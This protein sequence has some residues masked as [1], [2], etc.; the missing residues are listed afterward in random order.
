MKKAN[1]QKK[2]KFHS[3]F[4]INCPVCGKHKFQI[5]QRI[6]KI[7]YFGE[8]LETFATCD[9]CKYKTNDILPL[10]Q[11][12]AQSKQEL[13]VKT[14]KDLN[15]RL[16]KSKFCTIEIPEI[17]L[18]IEPGPGSEAFITNIEGLLHRI[19]KKI[20]TMK[21]LNPSKSSELDKILEKVKK[22]HKGKEKFTLIFRDKTGQSMIF[23]KT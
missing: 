22:M 10:E 6:D 16:V 20:G 5:V 11:K 14:Q 19:E 4:F 9:A 8:V 21:T 15:F 7:P 23:K 17:K 12:K 2:S 3:S 13:K 1:Q 18:K